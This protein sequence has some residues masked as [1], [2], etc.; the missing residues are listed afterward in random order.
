MKTRVAFLAILTVTTA[1]ATADRPVTEPGQAK[2]VKGRTGG[3][4]QE[5]HRSAVCRPC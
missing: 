4:M 3:K 5:G 2:L 1:P